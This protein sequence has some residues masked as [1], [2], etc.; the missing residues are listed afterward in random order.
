V[1]VAIGAVDPTTGVATAW[2]PGMG[3]GAGTVHAMTLDGTTL[4]AGGEFTAIGGATRTKAA[5]IDTTVASISSLTRVNTTATATVTST[6]AL[7]NGIFVTITGAS[8]GNYNEVQGPITIVDATHFTFPIGGSPTTPAT[9]T[10]TYARNNNAT[11]FNPVLDGDVH[12]MAMTNPATSVLLGG[13]FL[14]ANGATNPGFGG[15]NKTTGATTIAGYVY[16]VASVYRLLRQQDGKTVVAGD[17][18]LNTGGVFY[19]GLIRLN[20]NDT[21]DTSWNP[22]VDGQVVTADFGPIVPPATAPSTVLV[23]GSF[24]KIGTT[25]RPRLAAVSL[26]TG[27]ATSFDASPDSV[28]NKVVVDGTTAYIGGRFL[29]LGAAMTARNFIGAVDATTGATLSWYPAGGADDFVETLAVDASSVYAG[30]EFLNIGG[31]QRPNVAKMAKSNGALAAWNP[32]ADEAVFGLNVVGNT[33]YVSG[34]F[35]HL[36]GAA[37]NFVGAVDATTGAVTPWN[38]NPDFV[39]LGVVPSPTTSNMLYLFGAFINVNGTQTGTAAAVN[40]TTGALYPWFPLTNDAVYDLLPD[41]THVMM[42]GVFVDSAGVTRLGLAAFTRAGIPDPPG[43][44]TATA[45]NA[46]ASV[47]FAAPAN[48]GGSAITGYTVVSSPAG[49]VDSNAGSTATTHT[50]TGLTNGVSY[51]FTV[52]ATNANGTGAPSAPSNAVIPTAPTVPGPPLNVVAT[53]G[54]AQASVTFGAP[55]SNGGSP[56]TG[57]TVT[58]SP[59]GG[60]DSNAGSTALTHVVTNLVNGTA[61]TFTVKATN[62]VGTGPASAASNSVTPSAGAAPTAVLSPTSLIFS[63]T[64]VGV[65]SAAKTITLTNNGTATLSITSIAASGDYSQTNSCGSSLPAPGSCNINVVFTPTQAG[66]RNGTLTVTDNAS[67]S[68]HTASLTGTGAAAVDTTPDPFAFAPALNATPGAV[69]TSNTIT[70]TGINAAATITVSGG[71]YRKNGGAATSASGTVYNGDTIAAVGTAPAVR[72]QQVSV[73]VTIG[74]VSGTFVIS[75][76]AG[77]RPD[78]NGDGKTDL[79][80]R[81]SST[82]ASAAWLMNGTAT[83]S[84]AITYP[85]AGYSVTHTGDLSGDGKTD[86]L[87]RSSAGATVAW[88]MNGTTYSSYA[89]LLT[90]PNWV[91]QRVADFNGDGKADLLWHNAATGQT[92]IWLMNG[93]AT[94]SSAVILTSSSWSVIQVA[95]L[96]GDGKADLIWRNSASG[97]VA[98]WLMNGTSASSSVTLLSDPNWTV[99][100]TGD[101]NGDGKADLLWRNAT[102]GATAI[103]LMNGLAATSSAV[104]FTSTAWQVTH[105]GDF[106]GNGKA[107]LVWRNASTGQTAVWLMNGT[108]TASSATVLTDVNWSVTHVGDFDGNGTS[109]LVWRNSASGQTLVW[110]MN[111]TAYSSFGS[112]LTDPNWAVSPANGL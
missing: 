43:T 45:G 4:Y 68:P 2:N 1:R 104:V 70:V 12:S 96:N 78:L 56:I 21:L 101:F 62:A 26:T 10:I 37:R 100:R 46:S 112:I 30:G 60:V 49:G 99:T 92:A 95:D 18:F 11:A 102:T 82:G 40:T 73:V 67:G 64:T 77:N 88:L 13:D 5:G 105:V 16:D 47:S 34:N 79:L 17:F 74:G 71:Q 66:T 80:W 65:A 59:A 15:F 6:A 7:S 75:T 27:A 19:R 107:D 52:T 44:P 81:N 3:S 9:G 76:G 91:V 109:D 53:P 111:G 8:P 51:T 69:V 24:T 87:W 108:A 22:V 14:K 90:D 63:S 89:T 54:N 42:G 103:W 32:V 35:A 39:A 36:G 110:L 25:S 33:V 41:A 48:N 61:Y 97:Q 28:V 29:H 58:S 84:S 55:T 106:D 83:L 50:V 98:A 23:G 57:Y 72:N 31:A 93:L 86:L 85:N 94:T 20:A 38:P